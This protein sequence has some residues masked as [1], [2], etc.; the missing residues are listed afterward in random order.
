MRILLNPTTMDATTTTTTKGDGALRKIGALLALAGVGFMAYLVS[1]HYSVDPSSLCD[2]SETL[3]CSIVN[4]SVY[5]EL[6]GVPLSVLGIVYFATMLWAFLAKNRPNRY[7]I[8]TA[9]STFSLVFGVYLTGVE[10]LI[11]DSF[12]L[13]CEGA[14]VLMVLILAVAWF[15]AHRSGEKVPASLVAAACVVGIVFA[16]GA[17]ALQREPIGVPDYTAQAECLTE[18]GVVMY[19]AYWCPKCERQKRLFGD[20]FAAIAYV[21]CDPRGENAQAERCLARGIS[22]TPTWLQETADG[23]ELGRLEGVQD[24]SELAAKFDCTDI[25]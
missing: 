23:T 20:A 10:K 9:F 4:Q 6:L 13:F 25:E 16:A 17:F 1:L 5:S 8:I 3:N 7:L 22:G 15:G 19:G 14:K 18:K 21:E 2:L 11:L 24:V 12:C